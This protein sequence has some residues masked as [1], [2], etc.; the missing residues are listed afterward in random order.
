MFKFFGLLWSFLDFPEYLRTFL[1]F[2]IFYSFFE[3]NGSALKF[4]EFPKGYEMFHSI[5]KMFTRNFQTF[6]KATTIVLM[7][8]DTNIEF[9]KFSYFPDLHETPNILED[10]SIRLLETSLKFQQL[11]IVHLVALN[12]SKFSCS[13]RDFPKVFTIQLPWR[14]KNFPEAGWSFL[15]NQKFSRSSC[16]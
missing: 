12:F 5:Q 8:H 11:F 9:S 10:F 15:T 16:T 4:S 6:T 13:F 14:S 7:I 3:A 2:S 1:P